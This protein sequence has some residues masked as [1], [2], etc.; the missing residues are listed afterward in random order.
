MTRSH[1]FRF[2]SKD[3][4]VF[5][6]KSGSPSLRQTAPSPAFANIRKAA[7]KRSYPQWLT[8]RRLSLPFA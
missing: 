1:P 7:L 3:E 8:L 5:V 2:L 6:E 4:P